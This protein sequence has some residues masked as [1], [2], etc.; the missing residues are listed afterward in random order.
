M[1]HA[2]DLEASEFPAVG[3]VLLRRNDPG[4]G[5]EVVCTGTLV[6]P[7]KVLTAGHCGAVVGEPASGEWFFS[8]ATD[9]GL[10]AD[11]Y[12]ACP[13]GWVD[14]TQLR[15][16]EPS[17][18][19][20]FVLFPAGSDFDALFGWN[21]IAV[22][23][24]EEPIEDVTPARLLFDGSLLEGEPL[25]GEL[26]MVGYG[27]DLKNGPRRRA[28]TTQVAEIVASEVRY[29]GEAWRCK[30]DSGGPTFLH[31]PAYAEPV[32][33]SLASRIYDL[34]IDQSPC[35]SIIETRVDAHVAYINE[36]APG[37]EEAKEKVEN[38]AESGCKIAGGPM[39]AGLWGLLL[40]VLWGARQRLGSR[41]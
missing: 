1:T 3:A 5:H 35:G 25:A 33:V 29:D 27:P 20:D 39:P 17:A 2:R 32:L 11:A 7:D 36:A 23:T 30:G 8:L 13:S 41:L 34:K 10:G 6:A 16:I 18:H 26:E 22:W 31:S 15:P 9:L 19:P 38:E 21:D 28:A 24:L 14:D 37:A 12:L 40:M 4:C